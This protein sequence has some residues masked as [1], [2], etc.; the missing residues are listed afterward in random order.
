MSNT[1]ELEYPIGESWTFPD[2]IDYNYEQELR[3]IKI[4]K[5]LKL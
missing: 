5:I 2:D 1:L 3:D 4:E